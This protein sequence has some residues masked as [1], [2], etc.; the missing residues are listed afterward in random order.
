MEHVRGIYFSY[1]HFFKLRRLQDLSQDSETECPKLTII[2]RIGP[3][4][5]AGQDY[6]V[7][8]FHSAYL[9]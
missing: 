1:L 2:K 3:R 5:P 4:C 7:E 6:G 9:F 8:S